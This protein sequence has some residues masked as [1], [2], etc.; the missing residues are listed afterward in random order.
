VATIHRRR[1]D[2]RPRRV[3]QGADIGENADADAAIAYTQDDVYRS[4]I[5]A[6][7]FALVL[8][9]PHVLA[10]SNSQAPHP[11]PAVIA[12]SQTDLDGWTQ[13]SAIRKQTWAP[14]ADR[15]QPVGYGST[16]G[17]E[18]EFTE[19]TPDG[20]QLSLRSDV[21][22]SAQSDLDQD[23][24]DLQHD[25]LDQQPIAP[26]N[27]AL[28]EVAWWETVGTARQARAAAELDGVIIE[29][30]LTGAPIT[31]D[32]SL[33]SQ[34]TAWLEIM[35]DR[36]QTA[37]DQPPF[38][39]AR[40]APNLP[41]SLVLDQGDVGGDWD[42]A[43]GLELTSRAVASDGPSLVADVSYARTGGLYRR[44]L[45]SEVMVFGS[46]AA[47]AQAMTAGP[48]TAIVVPPLA[49]QTTAF[50]RVESDP[51]GTGD[52]L[53]SINV[54]RGPIVTS[55][56]DDGASTSLTSPDEAVD[57]ARKADLKLANSA[58]R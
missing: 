58:E 37:P 12:L 8:P 51:T 6:L 30:Q 20:S 28:N 7:W 41:W 32:N 4:F 18:S 19:T 50:R 2:Q 55:V 25:A 24:A 34:V 15:P 56:Q 46:A 13:T 47:A 1:A 17:L 5:V 57:L 33:E 22:E 3:H 27:P 36:A 9:A 23:F 44:T 14:Q 39:W 21:V 11:D 16:Y 31:T 38:D 54:R 48:G 42:Q 26:P 52:V 10:Q 29:L 40:L 53:Y 35:T 45:T 49:E 43:T